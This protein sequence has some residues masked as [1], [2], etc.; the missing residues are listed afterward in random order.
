MKYRINL[1]LDKKS[2]YYRAQRQLLDPRM[3]YMLATPARSKSTL[4]QP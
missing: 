1:E 2:E 4:L 3:L